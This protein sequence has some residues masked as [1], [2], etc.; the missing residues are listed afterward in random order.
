MEKDPIICTC[1]EI[2]KSVIEK[3]IVE[4]GLTTIEQV[5]DETTAGTFCGACVDDIYLMLEA[6]HGKVEL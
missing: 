2:R 5:Q 3:A 6:I 4:Q 1:L